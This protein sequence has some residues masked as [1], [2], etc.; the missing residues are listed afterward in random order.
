MMTA[1]AATARPTG[2]RN[3]PPDGAIGFLSGSGGRCPG[4]DAADG[5]ARRT[6]VR[7]FVQF[8]PDGRFVEPE[9]PEDQESTGVVGPG[10]GGQQGVALVQFREASAISGAGGYRR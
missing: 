2:T 4:A 3:S 9:D 7:V 10:T 1:S 5:D 8:R 6:V